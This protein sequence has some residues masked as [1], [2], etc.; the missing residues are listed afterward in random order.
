M[1][2]AWSDGHTTAATASRSASST[3]SPRWRNAS[4]G[5]MPHASE[6]GPSAMAYRRWGYS[7]SK[8]AAALPTAGH[9]STTSAAKRRVPI[10]V[11]RRSTLMS[12][13]ES[14]Y[15]SSGFGE[16]VDNGTVTAPASA[17]PR[18]EAT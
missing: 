9:S 11:W 18:N 16:Q 8:A 6:A 10:A 14:K 5:A 2:T 12:A 3:S 17:A 1:T 15:D 4:H 7:A 13:W